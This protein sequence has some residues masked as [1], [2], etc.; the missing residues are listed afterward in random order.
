MSR[1]FKKAFVTVSH[2]MADNVHSVARQLVRSRLNRL[3]AKN[4]D[5]EDLGIIDCDVHELG[6]EDWGT[7]CGLEFEDDSEYKE[8]MRRK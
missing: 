8:E 3:D 5:D 4:P 2:R 1:S 6:L 7:K